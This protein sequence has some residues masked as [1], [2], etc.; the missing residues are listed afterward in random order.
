MIDFKEIRNDDDTWELFTRDFLSELGFYI[1]SPPSRG[2]DG[3][4][5]LLVT[6]TIKGNIHRSEFRWLVSCKHYA[7]TSRSVNENDHEKNIL[8]RV[9]SFKADGFIG[10]YSTLASSGLGNRLNA[11]KESKDIKDFDIFDGRKIVNYL[12]T[13]G[14]SHLLMRYFPES[15]KSVK[16]LEL[17]SD[18]YEPLPCLECGKDLLKELYK[19]EYNANIVYA[20]K[21][22]SGQPNKYE[23]VYCCCKAC[24]GILQKKMRCMGFTTSW[25]DISD[26]TMPVEFLRYIFATMNRIRYG[27]DI[28]TDDAYKEEK[29]ILIALSQKVLRSTTIKERERFNLLRSLPPH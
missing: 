28:Y 29:A 7:H 6:E 17:V 14:Y 26:I 27:N 18:K 19:S 25:S 2:P 9:K 15:Y 20:Y 10:F 11:L 22:I 24:D 8:E 21:Y 13:V 4:K 23:K 3:G 12:I 1:E 5:D 16:P